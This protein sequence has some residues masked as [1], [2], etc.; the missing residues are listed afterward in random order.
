MIRT[1]KNTH[2][3]KIKFI[4]YFLIALIFLFV[5]AIFINYRF[6]S[7]RFSI[8]SSL[9]NKATLSLDRVNHTASKGGVKQW[10]LKA[11]TV[12]Y[13]Q[14]SNQALFQ[15]LTLVLFSENRLP[16]T[17]TSDQG[18][19]DTQTNNITATGHVVVING[20]YTLKTETLHYKEKERILTAPVPVTITKETSHITA[21]RMTMDM[22]TSI[23]IMEG[24]V[25]G[26][27]SGQ[28]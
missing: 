23:T 26:V 27:F 8:F 3:E 12:N 18:Q 28:F 16:T 25:K 15:S 21:D 19:L 1:S 14:D 13:F 7:G 17:L 9:D 4:F 20:P 2:P 11:A 5:V 6:I 22:N 10:S 24:H